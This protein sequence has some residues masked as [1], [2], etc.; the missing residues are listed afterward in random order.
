MTFWKTA[1]VAAALC[2]AAGV[3]AAMAPVGHA[4]GAR[5]VT[6]RN[7][8]VFSLGGGRLGVSVSDLEESDL[9]NKPSGGVGVDAVDEDS[10][11]AKAGL[12]KGDVVVEYDGERVRSVRQFS[13][14]VSETPVGR[15]VP[16]AVMRDGQRVAVNVAPRESDAAR[17]LRGDGWREFE[18]LRAVPRMPARPTTPRAA[19]LP[20]SI[21]TFMWGRGNQLGITTD[22]I[23]EQ[24]GEYFGVKQGVLVTHVRTDSVAAKVGL[25]AGDVITSVNGS[26]VEDT[27][28]LRRRLARMAGGE[29]FTLSVTRDKKSLTLKGKL[30]PSGTRRRSTTR[31]IL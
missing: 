6:P 13:R 30:E 5:V 10:P 20:P 26:T 4:Q 21:E 28:E 1:A 9:K 16:A 31:S 22:D 27:S 8:E 25:K 3:G 19:P 23:S 17:L 15:S 14:L 11:A 18:E 2:G 12:R 29:E 7:V 24:L